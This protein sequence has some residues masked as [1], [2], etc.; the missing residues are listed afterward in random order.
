MVWKA[1]RFRPQPYRERAPNGDDVHVSSPFS[2]S[3][4]SVRLSRRPYVELHEPSR[5]C[6]VMIPY[7]ER[8]E[9]LRTSAQ[10]V[11]HADNKKILVETADRYDQ[12]ADSLERN[13]RTPPQSNGAMKPVR[14]ACCCVQ[15][16]C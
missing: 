12:L 8:A 13:T 14:A 7:R 9:A 3:T 4:G 11:S 5:E 10:S 15:E 16:A 1:R 2:P 6:L